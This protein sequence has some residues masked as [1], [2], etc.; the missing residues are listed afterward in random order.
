[1]YAGDDYSDIKVQ[2][3]VLNILNEQE[4]EFWEV[5]GGRAHVYSGGTCWLDGICTIPRYT[6]IGI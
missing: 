4:V 2:R 6:Q 1:M 3:R 5:R